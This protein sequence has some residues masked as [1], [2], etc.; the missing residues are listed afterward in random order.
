MA[1][2]ISA[3]KMV[4]DP[5]MKDVLQI[6]RDGVTQDSAPSELPLTAKMSLLVRIKE[7]ERA[8]LVLRRV[9]GNSPGD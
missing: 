2:G 3:P 5:Q 7:K 1:G 6:L 9:W 8:G 4:Q